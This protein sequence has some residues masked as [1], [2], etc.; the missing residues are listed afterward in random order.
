MSDQKPDRTGLSRRGFL[1][2]AALSGAAGLV[3]GAHLTGAHAKDSQADGQSGP[4][5][6][7]ELD[8]YYAFNSGGP[9]GEVRILDLPSMRD[10]MRNTVVT[11]WT[12]NRGE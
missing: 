7:G 3:G 2:T 5:A 8:E 4:L 6:P 11:P 10:P 9:S 12:Q 1:G